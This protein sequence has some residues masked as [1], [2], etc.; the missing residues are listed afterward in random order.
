MLL[1]VIELCG[2]VRR[3]VCSVTFVAMFVSKFFSIGITGNIVIE[4]KMS[5]CKLSA[6]WFPLVMEKRMT[7]DNRGSRRKDEAEATS[8]S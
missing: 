1:W 5:A 7:E 8:R 3:Q 6:P 4:R 2:L